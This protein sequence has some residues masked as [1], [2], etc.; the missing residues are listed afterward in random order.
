MDAAPG[1]RQA[2][3]NS[4]TVAKVQKSEEWL[5]SATWRWMSVAYVSVHPGGEEGP[6]NEACQRGICPL[7]LCQFQQQPV[8]STDNRKSLC[9]EEFPV[10]VSWLALMCFL[11]GLDGLSTRN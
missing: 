11:S 1:G 3:N 6:R 2:R 5:P 7:F 8:T 9:S 4:V 10:P